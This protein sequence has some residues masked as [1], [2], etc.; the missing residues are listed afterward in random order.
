M[1]DI[2]AKLIGLLQIFFTLYATF[3]SV[4]VTH[5]TGRHHANLKPEQIHTAMMVSLHLKVIY[6]QL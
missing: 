4:G 3:S 5:G 2:P 1:N 6:P